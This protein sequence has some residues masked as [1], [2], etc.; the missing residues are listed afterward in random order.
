MPANL[1]NEAN[2]APG[3]LSLSQDWSLTT[4]SKT[5]SYCTSVD[6]LRLLPNLTNYDNFLEIKILQKIH[7]KCL[8]GLVAWLL[9]IVKLGI[10][11]VFPQ[12]LLC[13]IVFNYYIS[14]LGGRSRGNIFM[15]KI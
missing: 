1:N 8:S 14:P 15:Y 11:I 12:T 4:I 7:T 3:H 6:R 5:S 9:P 13:K 2:S 10:D